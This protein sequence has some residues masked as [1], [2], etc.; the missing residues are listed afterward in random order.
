MLS[1]HAVRVGQRVMALGTGLVLLA[2]LLSVPPAAASSAAYERLR[3]Q[4]DPSVPVAAVPLTS[5]DHRRATGRPFTAAEAVWPKAA[6]ADAVPTAGQ[7]QRAGDLPVWVAASAGAQPVRVE[8]MGRAEGGNGLLLRVSGAP[9]TGKVRLTVD[10]SGFRHAYGADWASRLRVLAL[11]QCEGCRTRT[12]ATDN[13]PA[14]GTVSAA[15]DEPL[16][17]AGTLLALAAEPSGPA[18]DYAATSL[19]PSWAWS[20]GGNSGSFSWSYPMRTPPSLGGPAPRIELGYSSASVDGRMPASNNQPSWAGEGFDWAPGFVERRYQ[21]CAAD[22]GTGANNT[23]RTGDLCWARDNAVLSLNGSSTELLKAADGTWHARSEDGSRVEHRTGAANGD[24]G[25]DEDRGEHW[26][27][28]TPDGT[29]YWF[30]RNRLPGWS[31]GKAETAAAWTVPVHGNHAGEPCHAAGFAASS[32][33]QAWRWNLDHVV[34]PFGNTMSYWYAK[35]T[36]AYAANATP[37]ALSA[38]VRGGHLTRI[39]YGTRS[40][41]AYGTAPMQVAVTTAD[42]CLSGCSARD[43]A[44]W[45]D[46]PWDQECKASPCYVGSPTFWTAKRLAKV[47]TRVRTGTAYRDV[48]SW[49]LTHSFP[50]PGDGTRAGLWLDRIGHS[51]GGASVP[52]VGFVGTQLP[53]RVDATEGHPAMNWW[54]VAHIDTETGGSVDVT[55]SPQ[56]CVRGSRMPSAPESN[57]LRCYPARWT[58]QGATAPILDYFHKYVVT[59]VTETDLA[60]PSNGRSPRSITSY[61]YVGAPAWHYTDDDG[62]IEDRYKTWS[63]WRGYSRVRVTK[64]DPGEQ[65]RTE[66]L[67]FRGM[68]GDRLPSG[69]RTVS[70]QAS[71]GAAVADLDAYA[72]M[73]REELTHNG[74]GGAVTEAVIKDP[75]QSAPTATRT[76]DGST[77]HARFTGVQAE[78]AR[79]ALDGGRGWRRT[80][81]RTSFDALGMAV[82]E[83][84]L[85]DLASDGDE[86]CTLT[87]YA[88]RNTTAWLVSYVQRGQEFAAGCAAVAAG[89]MGE[90]DVISDGYTR[91]DQQDRLTAPVKGAVSA[92][93]EL[94]AHSGGTPQYV[95]TSTATHDT[96]GRPLTGTDVRGN[97]TTTAYTPATGGPVTATTETNGLGWVTATTLDPAWGTRT[98]AV[99]PNGRRTD[100]TYDG[101][102]RLTAVW[103]PGRDK[104]GGDPAST[105]Y[106]YQV[107]DNGPGV[108]T[109]STVNASGAYTTSYELF[110]GL[111]RHR[112][113]QRPEAGSGGGKILTDTLY[114]TAGRVVRVNDDYVTDGA[115]ATNLFL[116]LPDAQIPS[117]TRTVYDGASR[118]TAEITYAKSAE[119]WRTTTAYAG[120]RVDTTP[121][122]GGTA[123]STVT[124]AQG[125][126]VALRQ[127]RAATPTGAFDTTTYTY[128][129]KGRLTAVIDP[130]GNRWERGYDLRGRQTMT[131]DPDK[132]RTTTVHDDAGDV[133]SQTDA[134]GEVVAYTYDLLGRRTT[135]RDDGPAGA[136]RA[137]WTYDSLAKGQPD[138]AIR[139]EAGAAYT[140]EVTGY[141]DEY[142]PTGR[143]ITVPGAEGGLAGTYTYRYTYRPDGSPASTTLP[144]AGGLPAERLTI[145]YNA[146]G[147]PVTLRTNLSG[148]GE[149]VSLVDGTQYTRYGEPAVVGRRHDSG[150][151]L[152]TG[153]YYEEGTR[154]LASIR[155]TRETAPSLV[156]DWRYSYDPMGNVTRLADAAAGDTQCFAYDHLRQ[157]TEAWTP[158][159][160]DCAAG[161]SVSALGGPAPYWQSFTHD[162]RTGNRLT[163]V[164]HAAAGDTTQTY[165]YPP[166]GAD[167]DRPHTLRSLTTRPPTGT[168]TTGTYG[169][170]ATGNTTTQPA[171]AGTRTLTWDAESHL[172]TSKDATG[173]TEYVYDAGGQRLLRRDP[174]GRTLYLPG[175]DLRLTGGDVKAA[176]RYYA[177]AG[178]I[179]GSR[180]P[181]SGLTWLAGDRQATAQAAVTATTQAITVRRQTPFGALR[182]APVTWPN[183]RGFLGG[184]VDGTGTTHLGARE[185]D[186]AT[187]RF[188]S[189]DP[190]TDEGD[191][192]QI[193]GYAYAHNAPVTRSDPTGL[194]DPDERDYCRRN[195]GD[196]N[197]GTLKPNP[198]SQVK[199]PTCG[200]ANACERRIHR[201]RPRSTCGSASACDHRISRRGPACG[202][203]NACERRREEAAEVVVIDLDRQPAD[204]PG[205][206]EEGDCPW[207]AGMGC[208][209]MQKVGRGTVAGCVNWGV[210]LVGNASVEHCVGM[211]KKGIF[212][213]ATD[214]TPRGSFGAGVGLGGGIQVSNARTAEQDLAGPFDFVSTGEG[215]VAWGNGTYVGSYGGGPGFLVNAGRSNTEVVRIYNW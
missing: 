185:Y 95:T 100:L 131:D 154:R 61:E 18:G 125:H 190:V 135:V 39:D 199:K 163:A 143:A 173:T 176:T 139:H 12:L 94:K 57:G 45:P 36:N 9:D 76:I 118:V 93:E 2:Q 85:G 42:R 122:A 196:C 96:H 215:A 164:S 129:R 98:S 6:T 207:W 194:F 83:E 22:M 158:A 141:D 44:H 191:P 65:T 160:G 52:D 34:D 101:L 167:S 59:T 38:Y 183:E 166:S 121:P 193:N 31:S 149:D 106:A 123:T 58:P 54:R 32:C 209:I 145:G 1:V 188:L 21:P 53:N 134:R 90:D 124:D 51:G 26:V 152:D 186:P 7:G 91:Y 148:D 172:A 206:K 16:G 151:I 128:D 108:V 200:S 63:V 47:T 179:V 55:Y 195:P 82:K 204:K 27:V 89:G 126:T 8:L 17:Q 78:N 147:L 133:I 68:H 170:D 114:D 115:P 60:L 97:T 208:V 33:A 70:V 113:T 187:G 64:G 69:T 3:P 50:D 19:Q 56:N 25:G 192:L 144:A 75:W 181:A 182:G 214:A 213:E 48:E 157:L 197:G 180:A 137:E 87:T 29:Q 161:R 201:E 49:T 81:T 132:G 202:S 136:K 138:A 210:A 211:D 168:A 174:G 103:R 67:Y 146:L 105:T 40:D 116:P 110:D 11:P 205:K 120:D 5:G 30:G 130:A 165:A 80:G 175:Q 107:R 41:T 104:A 23:A 4:D 159:A 162:P 71:E 171:A 72:G 155:T 28:T 66:T 119:K 74:P 142:R 20:A 127:Y 177:H 24:G 99:D 189:D 153:R 84:D 46:T 150:K 178:E 92:T 14:A 62:L 109:T 102:G 77:V 169:Y 73:P 112:Q 43:A 10:Y 86:R 140:D 13:D 212:W 35:E 198:P 184:T 203:A 117:W 79:A 15:L 37:T 111:L 156:S 88:P